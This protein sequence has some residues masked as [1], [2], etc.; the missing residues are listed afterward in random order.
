MSA[1]GPK[2]TSPKL[3]LT[4]SWMHVVVDTILSRSLG[5]HN[6]AARVHQPTWLRGD[7][8]FGLVAGR[9]RAAIDESLSDRVLGLAYR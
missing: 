2:R 6:E 4:P 3:R 5:G 8:A 7:S 9:I 1:I